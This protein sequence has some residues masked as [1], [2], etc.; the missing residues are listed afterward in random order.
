MEPLF[1]QRMRRG[2]INYRLCPIIPTHN[3]CS[4]LCRPLP[5]VPP[6]VIMPPPPS[7]FAVPRQALSAPI[8]PPIPLLAAPLKPLYCGM[9]M[10]FF[11]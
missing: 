3:L 4:T 10:F 8:S 5:F 11:L 2:T 1:Q 7:P 6:V 9:E